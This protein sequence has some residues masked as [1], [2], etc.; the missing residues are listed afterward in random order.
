MIT[1]NIYRVSQPKFIYLLQTVTYMKLVLTIFV[2]ILT[3]LLYGDSGSNATKSMSNVSLLLSGI[4]FLWYTTM[5][6]SVLKCKRK[7]SISIW[8]FYLIFFI[9]PSEVPIIK[10]ETFNNWYKLRTYFMANMIT[11]FP[12]HVCTISLINFTFS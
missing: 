10:K 8:I 5:M 4:M 7:I 6:P 3:G 11:T 9:V 12:I 2:A 1:L